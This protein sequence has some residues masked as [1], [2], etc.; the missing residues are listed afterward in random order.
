MR[1]R[2]FIM[3]ESLIFI[4]ILSQA[5]IFSTDYFND[6][7]KSDVIIVLGCKVQN[8]EPTRFLLERTLKANE[9]YK[10]GYAKYIILSGGK[11]EDEGISEAECMKRILIEQGIESDK[12]ILEDQ[13]KDTYENL[14]NSQ[15]IMKDKNLN[16]AIIVS[17]K[18]HLRRAKMISEK[19][20]LEASYSGVFVKDKWYKEMY[21]G[22]REVLGII[23]DSFR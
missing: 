21:G 15:K 4:L 23:K 22:L 12:L 16:R 1:K 10:E 2:I 3:I 18:F 8:E 11:G 7:K 6:I 20:K 17:N 13:S 19:L 14:V 5:F 9:L